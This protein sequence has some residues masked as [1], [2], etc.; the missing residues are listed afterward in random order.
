MEPD[1]DLFNCWKMTASLLQTNEEPNM[2][3]T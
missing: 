2:L 1:S 3:T